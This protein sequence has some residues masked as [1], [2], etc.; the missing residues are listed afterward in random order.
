MEGSCLPEGSWTVVKKISAYWSNSIRSSCSVQPLSKYRHHRSRVH[1]LLKQVDMVYLCVC[2]FIQLLQAVVDWTYPLEDCVKALPHCQEI[3][4]RVGNKEQ[5]FVT[6]LKLSWLSSTVLH[7]LLVMLSGFHVF[8]HNGS[9]FADTF[10]HFWHI[11]NEKS[12]EKL[13]LSD[14]IGCLGSLSAWGASRQRRL[15]VGGVPS[16]SFPSSQNILFSI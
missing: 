14:V 15:R 8:M 11:V 16:Y 4:G 13:E 9:D 10:L 6:W 12:K 3:A 1:P 2:M 5:H 7:S